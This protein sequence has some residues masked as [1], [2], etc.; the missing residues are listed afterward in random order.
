MLNVWDLY[1]V[2]MQRKVKGRKNKSGVVAQ[3]CGTSKVGENVAGECQVFGLIDVVE[4]MGDV[5]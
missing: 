3:K 4:R 1:G 5:L 2:N